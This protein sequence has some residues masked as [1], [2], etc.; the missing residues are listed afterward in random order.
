MTRL[1]IVFKTAPACRSMDKFPD[2]LALAQQIE[3]GFLG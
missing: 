1:V 2:Q 3:K